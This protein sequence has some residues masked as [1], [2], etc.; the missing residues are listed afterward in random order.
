MRRPDNQD[1]TLTT[2]LAGGGALLAVADG[3]GGA[4]AGGLAAEI[5]VRYLENAVS[6]QGV[7]ADILAETLTC[8]SREIASFSQADASLDG[9]GTT[10]TVVAVHDGTASWAHVGDS[11]LYHLGAGGLRQI[12]RDH[13]FLQDLIDCGDVTLAELPGHPL[14]NVLDQCLGCPGV[15]PDRGSFA[16]SPRDLLLL[17]SDGVHDHVTPDRMAELL[18]SAMCLEDMAG[19]LIAEARRAGSTDDLSAVLCRVV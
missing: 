12:S 13:R 3:M 5:A 19:A 6:G 16:V 18:L 4:A 10:L 11:R 15:R 8:A 2:R 7:R 9:M 17:T 1:R 14:R